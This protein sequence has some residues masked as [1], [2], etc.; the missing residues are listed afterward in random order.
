MLYILMFRLK[1]REIHSLVQEQNDKWLRRLTRCRTAIRALL[2]VLFQVFRHFAV[3][4]GPVF[5]QYIM[6]MPGIDHIIH[7]YAFI[8]GGSDKHYGMLLDD[9]RILQTMD[10]Q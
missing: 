10:Q 1:I 9:H 7:L 6:L 5:A 2:Q 4:M 8:Y 3:E